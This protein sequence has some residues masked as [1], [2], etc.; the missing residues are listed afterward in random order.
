[1]S[2]LIDD[3]SPLRLIQP[4]D[5]L[6]QTHHESSAQ[7]IGAPQRGFRGWVARRRLRQ[8]LRDLADDKHLLA[9]IGLT[10]E[11]AREEAAKP[12]WR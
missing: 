8:A 3:A 6:P 5:P 1:M 12:F 7:G 10:P 2:T 4:A 11:E 9:D